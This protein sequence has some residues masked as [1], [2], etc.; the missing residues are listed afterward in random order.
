M[1]V[2]QPRRIVPDKGIRSGKN[3]SGSPILKGRIVKLKASPGVD[4]E[5]IPAAAASDAF[6]GVTT[7]DIADGEWGDI[8]VEGRA[9]VV[10]GAAIAVE[11]RVTF[12]TGAKGAAA[13]T[14]DSVLGIAVT[15]ATTDGDEIEVD[16]SG[17]GGAAMP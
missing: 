1:P 14:G 2:N 10:A 5:V 16:L 9:V 15:E 4:D 12:G 3:T 11:A 17:P 13:S 7:H 8:Q 6:Y